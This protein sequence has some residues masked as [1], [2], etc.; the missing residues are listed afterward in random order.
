MGPIY[1]VPRISRNLHTSNAAVGGGALLPE[2]LT[3]RAAKG[4]IIFWLVKQFV[5][6]RARNTDQGSV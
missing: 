1:S 3:T 5:N 4:G 6:N 2:L